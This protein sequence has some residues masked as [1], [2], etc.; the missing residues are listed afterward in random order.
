MQQLGHWWK[1]IRRY[2][3]QLGYCALLIAATWLHLLVM[4][5]HD[6]AQTLKEIEHVNDQ[7]TRSFEENLRRS[8]FAVEEQLLLIKGEYEPES[9]K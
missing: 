8:L 2:W 5:E 6:H 1:S 3:V 9:G 7:L 4:L